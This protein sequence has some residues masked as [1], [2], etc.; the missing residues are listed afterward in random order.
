[1]VR[2]SCLGPSRLKRKCWLE[3]RTGP[4]QSAELPNEP[5]WPPHCGHGDPSFTLEGGGQIV[6][7]KDKVEIGNP[8]SES[9]CTTPN[10]G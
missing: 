7:G 2:P 6:L 1:V 5:H 10:L 8:G 3:A 9:N 4:S